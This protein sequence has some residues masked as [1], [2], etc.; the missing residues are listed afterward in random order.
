MDKI[1]S[2]IQLLSLFSIFFIY[3]FIMGYINDEPNEVVIW[4]MITLVYLISLM[5][6]FFISKNNQKI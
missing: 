1:K 6:L 3:K 5:I 4:G 2:R